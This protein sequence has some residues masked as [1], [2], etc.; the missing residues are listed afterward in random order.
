MVKLEQLTL[1]DEKWQKNMSGC[2][3]VRFINTAEN[4]NLRGSITVRLDLMFI[5]FGLSC[6]AY[7]ERTVLLVWS[8]PNKSNRRSAYCDT[9]AFCECSV[10]TQMD[11][12]C[13]NG[14]AYPYDDNRKHSWIFFLLPSFFLH[15]LA[16]LGYDTA[17]KFDEEPLGSGFGTVD[18][19]VAFDT[20]GPGFESNNRQLL[21]NKFTVNFLIEKTKI[22]KKRARMAHFLSLTKN[23]T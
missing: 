13:W 23:P 18:S 15:F 14:P 6:F 17:W 22:R 1:P 20:R 8:N 2:R 7:V 12:H 11:F 5:L 10:N 21:M 9:Y 19:A 4:T 16:N 3:W